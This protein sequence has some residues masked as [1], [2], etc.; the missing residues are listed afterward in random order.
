M[1]KLADT[2]KVLVAMEREAYGIKEEQEKPT[3]AL[4]ELLRQVGGT[5]LPIVKDNHEEEEG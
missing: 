4:A 2:L 1:K 3:N 5:G